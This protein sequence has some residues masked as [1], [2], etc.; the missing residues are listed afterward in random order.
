MAASARPRRSDRPARCS[1]ATI[2]RDPARTATA[3]HEIRAEASAVQPVHAFTADLS[4]QA[5]VRRVAAEV[6]AAA[7]RLDVL[8]NNVGGSWN[9]RHTTADGL[10]RTFVVN[11]LPPFLVTVLLLARLRGTGLTRVMNVASNS[12]ALGASTWTLCRPNASTPAPA[13]PTSR[14]SPTCSSP[15]SS[16]GDWQAPR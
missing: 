7:P 2:G 11:H 5:E 10:E 8:I 14:S 6:L 3:A 15:M 4:S 12:Q 9:T 16:L 1:V 13:P